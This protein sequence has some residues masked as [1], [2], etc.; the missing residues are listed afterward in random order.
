MLFLTSLLGIFLFLMNCCSVV[1]LPSG[2]EKIWDA[3]E[4]DIQF[5]VAAFSQEAETGERLLND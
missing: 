1:A 5:T 4:K 2:L 3:T